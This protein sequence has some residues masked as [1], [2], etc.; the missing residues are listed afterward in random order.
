MQVIGERLIHSYDTERR[1][2][3][4]GVPEQ[5]SSTKHAAGVTCSACRALLRAA[6]PAAG[7]SSGA[8]EKHG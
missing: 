2:V 3:L 8:D 1:R 4:C 7:A 6:A 5:T